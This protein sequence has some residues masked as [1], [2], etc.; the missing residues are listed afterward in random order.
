[1]KS[2]EFEEFLDN[3]KRYD[4]KIWLRILG[5]T[6]PQYNEIPFWVLV[7]G[8]EQVETTVLKLQKELYPLQGVDGLNVTLAVSSYR[9][10]LKCQHVMYHG[11]EL[12]SDDALEEIDYEPICRERRR[13]LFD[14][15][16]PDDPWALPPER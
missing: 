2:Q 6:H 12:F 5:Q 7:S 16:Y 11:E 9:D 3:L 1:M 15:V 14:D 4:G 13:S 10:G 8:P